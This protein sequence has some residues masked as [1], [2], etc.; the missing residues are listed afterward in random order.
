MARQLRLHVAGGFYHVTLRGNHRQAIFHRD[1]DRDLLDGIVA[2]SLTM[3]A[4]RLH[5]YCWMTNHV[6]LLVQV[7]DVPL[8][9]FV[10]RVA[11]QYARRIQA[12]METTGHL[13]ERRY[14][15]MLVDADAYLLT[16]VRYIHMNPVR[17]GLV[18]EAGQYP[19]SSHRDYLGQRERSWLQTTFALRLLSTD[20]AAS[21]RAYRM[22]MAEPG[23]PS[24]GSE[25]LVPN[26]GNRQVLGDDSFAARMG[27]TTRRPRSAKTLDMLIAECC[28]RFHATP[29][30]LLS[31]SRDRALCSARAW[32]ANEAVAGRIASISAVA[33]RLARSET[34]VRQ[35]VK[36]RSNS[37]P[38]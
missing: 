6:H 4:S 33:R 8:G 32:L 34:A 9:K 20:G 36:R 37:P 15:A 1:A 13:F 19:W 28:G 38:K 11:S 14:H 7:S 5:A 30:A 23:A 26:P 18:S 25:P 31:S 21:R 17:G 16:L 2:D 35:L 10:L 3:T 29:E 12:R 22:F 27:I 24:W